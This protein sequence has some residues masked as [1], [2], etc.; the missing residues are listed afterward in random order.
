MTEDC[1]PSCSFY[2]VRGKP[3]AITWFYLANYTI[4]SVQDASRLT[5][6]YR[7]GIRKNDEPAQDMLLMKIM[8]VN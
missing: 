5:T 3:A 7:K 1:D 4:Y 2:Y 8:T 6:F